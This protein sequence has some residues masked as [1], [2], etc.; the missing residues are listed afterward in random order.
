MCIGRPLDMGCLSLWHKK[1]LSL[2]FMGF[3]PGWLQVACFWGTLRYLCCVWYPR[4]LLQS[5]LGSF[6]LHSILSLSGREVAW[7]LSCRVVHEL[8][9]ALGSASSKL[10]TLSSKLRYWMQYLVTTKSLANEKH[11]PSY[12]SKSDLMRT[13]YIRKEN[14]ETADTV[15]RINHLNVQKTCHGSMSWAGEHFQ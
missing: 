1:T 2:G 14:R 15:P 4:R 8:L 11:S 13:L 9:T 10:T 5:C 3:W 12:S 7:H 6:T